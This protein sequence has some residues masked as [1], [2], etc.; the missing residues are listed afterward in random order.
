MEEENTSSIAH[1]YKQ[2]SFPQSS[3]LGLCLLSLYTLSLV[4][5]ATPGA[6]LHKVG[7]QLRLTVNCSIS[8]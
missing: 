2:M 5:K 8:T 1:P 7:L 6:H 3:V 4:V